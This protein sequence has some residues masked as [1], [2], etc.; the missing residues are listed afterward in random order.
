MST[1]WPVASF[2]GLQH[3]QS[4]IVCTAWILTQKLGKSG[5]MCCITQRPSLSV[6][7]CMS[8]LC[9]TDIT[10]DQTRPP[11]LLPLKLVKAK[12]WNWHSI[13]DIS[14]PHLPQSHLLHFSQPTCVK[15]AQFFDCV[16]KLKKQINPKISWISVLFQWTTGLQKF[17]ML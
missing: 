14:E 4:L 15:W 12:E 17:E 11:G 5:L 16:F 9:L 10:H 3:L 2:L 8:T 13:T 7:T 1:Y 6:P